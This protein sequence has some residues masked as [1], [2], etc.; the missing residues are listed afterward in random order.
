MCAG[1]TTVGRALA[2]QLGWSFCDLDQDIEASEGQT[3]ARL[4]A[5]LGESY[6]RRAETEAL[7]RRVRAIEAGDA[8]VIAVGGGAFIQSENRE[9]I[10]NNGVTVWLDCRLDTVHRRLGAC[11]T[12]PLAQDPERLAQLFE[13]RRAVYA[14]ADF[15]IET[16]TDRV[17]DVVSGILALPIF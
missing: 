6:F 4:F 9:L 1:K 16:D 13:D 11:Q 3:V 7:R 10:S 14:Q 15:R 5:D 8:S 12:R 2:D 17:R